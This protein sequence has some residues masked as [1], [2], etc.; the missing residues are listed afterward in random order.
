MGGTESETTSESESANA[1]GR[2][3]IQGCC[4]L[5]PVQGFVAGAGCAFCAAGLGA[6]CFFVVGWG[7]ALNRFLLWVRWGRERFGVF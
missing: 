4:F 3:T 1:S 2:K 5:L 7:G 6:R